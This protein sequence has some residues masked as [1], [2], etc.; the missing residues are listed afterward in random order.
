MR[1]IVG[2]VLVGLGVAL[3]VLAIALPTYVYPRVAVAPDNPQSEVVAKGDGITVLLPRGADEGG[4][5]VLTDQSVTVTRFVDQEVRP[6]APAPADDENFYR[7]QFK[8]EV[9]GQGLLNAYI[10]GGSFDTRTGAANNC[11]GDY[12]KLDATDEV[13]T[14]VRHSGQLFKFPFDTQRE[15]YEFWD[16]NTND[17]APA[18]FDGTERIDGLQTY[19]FVQTIPDT[20]IQ[21]QEIPGSLIGLDQPSV[22]ADR[23]YA[24]TRTLWVEPLTGAI[25]K[26]SEEVDQRLALDGK[27]APVIQGTITYTDE[28]VAANVEEYTD[29]AAS[30]QFVT[31]TGPIAGWV[32]G[33]LLLLIGITLVAARG[34]RQQH[35]ASD[36]EHDTQYQTV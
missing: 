22:L 16:V 18:R 13:G 24:T 5:R 17:S 8:A 32:L 2:L 27:T 6:D 9:D 36:S 7:V 11:C 10:Q 1:R 35:R 20:V 30:L 33:V 21:Q 26:G 31:R 19:R 28:T 12:I 25:I 23:I 14:P 34:R 3:I 29:S 15:D 4:V